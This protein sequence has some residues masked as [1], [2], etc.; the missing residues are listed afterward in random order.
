MLGLLGGPS[1]DCL[2]GSVAGYLTAVV[3]LWAVYG[4]GNLAKGAWSV[5]RL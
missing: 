4:P 2:S 1:L 3:P 5:S